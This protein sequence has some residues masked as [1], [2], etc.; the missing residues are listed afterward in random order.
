MNSWVYETGIL[1]KLGLPY[2]EI[3]YHKQSKYQD[4]KIV[5]SPTVGRLLILDNIFR[6]CEKT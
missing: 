4:V 1:S 3:L 2:S 6:I 5:E